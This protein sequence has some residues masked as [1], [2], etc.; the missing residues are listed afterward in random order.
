MDLVGAL[1]I[2]R[3]PNGI[4][5]SFGVLTGALIVSGGDI[6][7]QWLLLGMIT[8]FS[9]N[10]ASMIL[11][12]YVDR[13]IDAINNPDRP[14]VTGA[15]SVREALLMFFSFTLLGILSALMINTSCFIIALIAMIIATLYNLW[16]KRAGFWGNL[17]VAFT[18]AVP[19]LFGGFIKYTGNFMTIL[20]ISLLAFL[21]NVGREIIKGI[22]DVRGDA[23]KG[24]KT[25]A[26]VYG[27]EKSSKIASGFVL[28]AVFLSPLPFLIG[29]LRLYGLP[30]IF[31]ADMIFIISILEILLR[32]T[33]YNAF[34]TKN[35]FL[36]AMFIGIIGFIIGGLRF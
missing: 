5:M 23:I 35:R 20:T 12:D 28:I 22:A 4:M 11:N 9:L 21:S 15:V 1:K 34:K 16:G 30:V 26:V 29:E 24:I 6:N 36:L 25:V 27:P 8:G 31:I 10:S 19:F 18:T 13:D 2:I 32:P 33:A 14:L 17:M 3:V 7:L